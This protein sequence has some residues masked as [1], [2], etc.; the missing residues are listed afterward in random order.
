MHIL[1]LFLYW[2]FIFIIIYLNNDKLE[3][4]K[5]KTLLPFENHS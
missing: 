4:S 5:G 2:F 1:K 3:K